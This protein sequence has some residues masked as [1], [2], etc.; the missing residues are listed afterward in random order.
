MIGLYK[1]IMVVL[2]SLTISRFTYIDHRPRELL[3]IA[4]SGLEQ[5]RKLAKRSFNFEVPGIQF[6]QTLGTELIEEAEQ[7]IWW[8]LLLLPLLSFIGIRKHLVLSF[9]VYGTILVFEY[10]LYHGNLEKYFSVVYHPLVLFG[11]SGLCL[12]L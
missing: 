9:L 3:R 12:T 10:P 5:Y 11:L 2:I 1:Y 8:G 7:F 6:E 4:D